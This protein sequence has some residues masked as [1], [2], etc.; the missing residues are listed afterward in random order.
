MVLTTNGACSVWLPPAEQRF[1]VF[2]AVEM[3]SVL[4]INAACGNAR[5]FAVWAMSTDIV[6]SRLGFRMLT[7][8]SQMC[9]K[10]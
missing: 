9:Y 8:I 5:A 3:V 4:W 2:R 7:E 6:P 10:N 1:C